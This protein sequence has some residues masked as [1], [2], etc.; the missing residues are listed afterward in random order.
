LLVVSVGMDKR[1]DVVRSVETLDQINAPLA[2]IVLNRAQATDSSAYYHYGYD[3]RSLYKGKA[4]DQK[5]SDA[6]APTNGNGKVA[7]G[8]NPLQDRPLVVSESVNW[9]VMGRHAK[10]ESPSSD[11]ATLVVPPTGDDVGHDQ[12]E[13]KVDEGLLGADEPLEHALDAT[14]HFGTPTVEQALTNGGGEPPLG[15]DHGS[16]D[17][18]EDVQPDDGIGV[19]VQD[20]VVEESSQDE[21]VHGSDDGVGDED[22]Q[23][24]LVGD[25]EGEHAQDDLPSSDSATLVVPHTGGAR[26]R[27]W[28]RRSHSA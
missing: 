13:G 22:G 3:E 27:R 28:W 21:R 14:G 20:L 4:K 12:V 24:L 9:P 10:V 19:V 17:T 11:S 25:G 18:G 8:L 16:A 7:Q 23:N 5:K 2:G 6:P 15:R 26:R 1:S